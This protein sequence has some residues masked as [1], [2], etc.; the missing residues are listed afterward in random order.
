MY[1][2]ITSLSLSN[3]SSSATSLPPLNE[4]IMIF[5]TLTIQLQINFQELRS[6]D[7]YPPISALP[8][9]LPIDNA[10]NLE[11]FRVEKHV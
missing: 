10:H 2:I 7:A 4:C 6:Q 5:I 11:C 3:N 9:A 1:S 8:N